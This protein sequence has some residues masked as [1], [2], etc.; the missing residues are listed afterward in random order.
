[1]KTYTIQMQDLPKIREIKIDIEAQ[2]VIVLYDILDEA[3]G[4]VI[5][6]GDAT[7]WVTIPDLGEDDEGN[8]LPAPE[9]WFQ[10]PDGYFAT[11]VDLHNAAQT[12]IGN[13][14]ETL[15]ELML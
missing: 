9:T 15:L 14:L 10:I 8:P 13:K 7:F 11:L 3:T 4:N 12:A 2:R 5:R 1:M 6:S